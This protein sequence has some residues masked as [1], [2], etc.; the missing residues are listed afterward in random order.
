MK[1][2]R[3]LL[4]TVATAALLQTYTEEAR[5]ASRRQAQSQSANRGSQQTRQVA[6]TSN[7]A[8]RGGNAPANVG[9][10]NGG[11]GRNTLTNNGTISVTGGAGGAASGTGSVGGQGGNA[12]L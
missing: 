7:M 4:L 9:N 1:P 5:A 2:S 10:S 11:R 3:I 8:G 12:S 6:A